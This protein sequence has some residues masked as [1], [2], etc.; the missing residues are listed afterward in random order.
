M[1]GKITGTLNTMKT[2][3]FKISRNNYRTFTIPPAAK[4]Q[5]I[6]RKHTASKRAA[7]SHGEIL[8]RRNKQKTKRPTTNIRQP[9]CRLCRNRRNATRTPKQPC[10]QDERSTARHT[11]HNNQVNRWQNMGRNPSNMSWL[12]RQQR[13][14]VCGMPGCD[15][16]TNK[17]LASQPFTTAPTCQRTPSQQHR[18]QRPTTLARGPQRHGQQPAHN[19]FC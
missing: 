11:A 15:N 19:T 18:R 10:Y 12:Q 16:S 2:L 8:A 5:L 6:K 3:A 13:A 1:N 17:P 14:L 7:T 4:Y 9:N